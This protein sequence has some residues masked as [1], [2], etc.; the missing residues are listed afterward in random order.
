M[1]GL[2]DLTGEKFGRLTVLER[3]ENRIRPSGQQQ[4]MWKCVCDCGNKC[5]VEGNELR[6]GNTQSCGCY[7]NEC[8]SKRRIKTNEYEVF[9][10]YAVGYTLKGEK[11]YIDIDD[12]DVVKPYC[13]RLRKDGY[14]DAKTRNGTNE[15]I[16]MHNLIMN[17]KYIDHINGCRND[18]RKCNLRLFGDE[19][20]FDTYNQMNKGI[21]SNNTLSVIGVSYKKRDNVWSAYISVDNKR[22]YLGE[23]E[24]FDDAVKARKAAEEK[25]FGECS[26]EKSQI[27]SL[28]II[29][30]DK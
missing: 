21:Q 2:I 16:L 8:A 27:Q 20:S 3:A 30:E 24:N 5:I 26:Y 18:N 1:G 22:Y 7:R 14:L 28:E 15:R 11:F 25:Y 9:Q 4:T 29:M 10:N 12:I 23:Y 6:R 19:H 13:W 17:H